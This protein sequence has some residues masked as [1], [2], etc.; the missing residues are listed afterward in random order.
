MLHSPTRRADRDSRDEPRRTRRRGQRAKRQTKQRRKRRQTSEALSCSQTLPSARQTPVKARHAPRCPV[1]K[2]TRILPRRNARWRLD[3]SRET[4]ISYEINILRSMP[5]PRRVCRR[6]PSKLLQSRSHA[7]RRIPA[8]P[9]AALPTCRGR[10]VYYI[11]R[12]IV[13]Q[14]LTI[15]VTG[16]RAERRT[17]AIPTGA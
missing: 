5:R 17:H 2:R 12:T 4:F 13:L 3:A 11:K 1:S 10:N 16:R 14:L 15:R 9:V 7:D 6:R 8:R